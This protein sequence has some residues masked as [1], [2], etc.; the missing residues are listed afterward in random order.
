MPHL[1][2][3]IYIYIYIFSISTQGE[4]SLENIILWSPKLVL[5]RSRKSICE[6]KASLW[7][8]T[9]KR[10]FDRG[11]SATHTFDSNYIAA[12][13]VCL[14]KH[15]EYLF[16]DW[17]SAGAAHCIVMSIAAKY[18]ALYQNHGLRSS[19]KADSYVAKKFSATYVAEISFIL[20][21]TDP[22]FTLFWAR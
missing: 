6:R 9:I 3:Y 4:V 7:T 10:Y 2:I 22:Q 13:S 18:E 15:T 14:L 19:Q 16:R 12:A 11:D 1:Y 5:Q 20:L 21:T 17:K 8:W